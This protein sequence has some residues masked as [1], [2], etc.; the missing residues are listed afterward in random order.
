[1]RV[2]KVSEMIKKLKKIG[3]Y[4][5]EHGKEHDEWYSPVTKKSFRV[6]RHPSKDLAKGTA[7]SIMK[8]SGL[9]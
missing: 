8:D 2:L 1:M 6:P 3:C 4:I 5:K 9:K 7:H